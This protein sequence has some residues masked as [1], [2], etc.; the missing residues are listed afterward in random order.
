MEYLWAQGNTNELSIKNLNTASFLSEIGGNHFPEIFDDDKC[1]FSYEACI[2]AG[3][4][5]S[6]I[7]TSTPELY[8]LHDEYK[9]AM[10]QAAI[11]FMMSEPATT[12][13]TK[14]MDALRALTEKCHLYTNTN[15]LSAV[16]FQSDRL[17]IVHASR[18]SLLDVA[19]D[20]QR[21]A[22]MLLHEPR[23]HVKAEEAWIVTKYSIEMAPVSLRTKAAISLYN[24]YL[25]SWQQRMVDAPVTYVHP[26]TARILRQQEIIDNA[27]A[28]I[29][30]IAEGCKH[31]AVNMVVKHTEDTGNFAR[32][33]DSFAREETCTLCGKQEYWSRHI[34]EQ[35]FTLIST[36]YRTLPF[37]K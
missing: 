22:L 16:L 27:H 14:R 11:L 32:S 15:V 13:P 10:T 31:P 5:A 25:E 28:E 12:A 3:F 34:G 6:Y 7:V 1:A 35:N 19:Y 8:E 29:K 20:A 21:I 23:M 36:S 30:N 37:K 24:R 4:V 33:D 26:I 2:I 17:K 18:M 9:R